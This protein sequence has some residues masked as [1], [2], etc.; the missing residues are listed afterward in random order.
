[1]VNGINAFGFFIIESRADVT[2]V[3]YT[4]VAVTSTS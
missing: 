4:M 2:S 1:M 3:I